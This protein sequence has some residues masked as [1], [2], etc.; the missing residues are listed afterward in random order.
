MRFG[1][2]PSRVRRMAGYHHEMRF[3]RRD[4]RT[5]GSR[6]CSIAVLAWS[7]IECRAPRSLRAADDA[8]MHADG[9]RD[10]AI[11]EALEQGPPGLQEEGLAAREQ[12]RCTKIGCS[13]GF[14]ATLCLRA[15]LSRIVSS[16][17]TFCLNGRCSL[18]SLAPL[19]TPRRAMSLKLAAP[20]TGRIDMWLGDGDVEGSWYL[21]QVS[22]EDWRDED[23]HDGDSYEITIR[24]SDG[25]PF[26]SVR[27]KAEYETYLPNGPRCGGACRKFAIGHPCFR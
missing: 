1:E 8:G 12:A 16:A 25:Q 9:D 4:A 24:S 2:A 13:S 26:L 3:A 22:G 14:F 7:S 18:A 11:P 5:L 27:K 21:L 15:S 20:G 19:A 17:I 6:I 23:L 10:A